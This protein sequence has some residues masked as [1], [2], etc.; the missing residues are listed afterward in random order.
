MFSVE[1]R[2]I[3]IVLLGA[4]LNAVSL[5]L[6]LIEANVYASGFTGTA[7]L[8]TSILSDFLGVPGISTGLLLF[9]LNI[10]VA[11]LGWFKVGKGFTVYSA[12]SVAF[13]TLFL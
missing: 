7:Q 9:L 11:I 6:F 5:N 8:L 1:L 4:V 13:T 10:P 2:R 3:V 12:V